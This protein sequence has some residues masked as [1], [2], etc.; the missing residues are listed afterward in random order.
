MATILEIYD[1]KFKIN[2]ELTYNGRF[3]NG[4]P[5]E[6]LLFNVRAVQAIFD[7]ENSETRLNWIYPDTK[8]WDPER[9]TEEFIQAL[10]EWKSYGVLG[11]TVNLQGGMP[12]VKTEF[13]Q[14]WINTAFYPNGELKESYLARLKKILKVADEIGMVCIVGLFYFG[15]DERLE[16]EKAV[17]N[18]VDNA[19][20]WLLET[21]YRNVMIEINNEANVPLYQHSIL[22]P[23]RVHELII[24]AR[25]IVEGKI[26]ISTSFTGGMLPTPPVIENSDFVLV[27]GNGLSPERIKKLVD[28]I[29]N[30]PEYRNN[31]KPIVFN[32]DGVDINNLIAAFEKY[33]SWGYYD[34]GQN[35]YNDGFQ[36]PPVNWKVNTDVKKRFFSKV[37]E[38]TGYSF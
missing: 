12:I 8:E 24:R 22:Q 34:Q 2:G 18:G 3:Y 27:H 38:I 19:V 14:P 28:D 17:I 16:D 26:P 4:K 35:N 37:A 36:S 7:D 23:S 1:E 32:E 10:P 30:T 11:F 13:S 33:A 6:G 25:K 21:G 9:N 5:V 29:R 15:Q 31:P 20:S